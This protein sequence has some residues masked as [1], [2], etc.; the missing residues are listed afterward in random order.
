MSCTKE[1]GRKDYNR[2]RMPNGIVA[3]RDKKL[4]HPFCVRNLI[5]RRTDYAIMERPTMEKSQSEGK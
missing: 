1:V 2:A 5:I 3:D 4:R